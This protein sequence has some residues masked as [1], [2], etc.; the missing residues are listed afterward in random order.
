MLLNNIKKINITYSMDIPF[1]VMEMLD[2]HR[3]NIKEGAFVEMCNGLMELRKNDMKSADVITI[4]ILIRNVRDRMPPR[5]PY[6][7]RSLARIIDSA[8]ENNY[9][10]LHLPIGFFVMSSYQETFIKDSV[11]RC[12]VAGL[13]EHDPSIVLG[14]LYKYL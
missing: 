10:D 2:T 9:E 3:Q 11:Y 6:F 4:D 8:I 14:K 1:K 5:R 13:I 12:V 7:Y